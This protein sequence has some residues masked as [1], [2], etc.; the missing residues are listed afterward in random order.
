MQITALD[1]EAVF[2]PAPADFEV[3]NLDQIVLAGRGPKA[4]FTA[5]WTGSVPPEGVD[6]VVQA[7]WPVASSD[8]GV[9][10]AAAKFTV[11]FSDGRR[12]EKSFWAD[13]TGTLTDVLALPGASG[14]P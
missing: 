1:V 13:A 4:H 9:A 5:R 12:V 7:H 2:A 14:P 11:Q 8:S 10:P 3:K 6:L